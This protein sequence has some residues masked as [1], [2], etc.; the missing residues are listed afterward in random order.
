MSSDFF[1][2]KEIRTG[3]KKKNL[4]LPLSLLS[5]FGHFF[6]VNS[7]QKPLEILPPHTRFWRQLRMNEGRKKVVFWSVVAGEWFDGDVW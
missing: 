2:N 1:L 6:P 7:N 4:I 5:L 3:K